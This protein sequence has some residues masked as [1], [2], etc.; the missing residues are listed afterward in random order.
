VWTSNAD[1][2]FL[3]GPSRTSFTALGNSFSQVSA[4][5]YIY[6]PG[7]GG[8]TVEYL[9]AVASDANAPIKVLLTR[10]GSVTNLGGNVFQLDFSAPLSEYE[11]QSRAKGESLLTGQPMAGG[12][13][14]APPASQL[15]V[16]TTYLSE[17][18]W[19]LR[20]ARDPSKVAVF[21]RTETRS[22][23]DRRGLVADGQ[24]KPPDDETIRYGRL[25]FGE[26]LQDYAGWDEKTTKMMM[27]KERLLAR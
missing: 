19:I 5:Q 26:T 23:M 14:R 1:A 17:R 27:E 24:L 11:V 25:L 21:Q 16:Q 12:V 10:P 2:A 3:G 18:M 9:H 6:G 13:E 22:V 15:L 8:I 20:D 7:E 4:R